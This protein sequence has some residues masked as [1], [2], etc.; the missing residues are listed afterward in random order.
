MKFK[1]Q[2]VNKAIRSIEEEFQSKHGGRYLPEKESKIFQ[3]HLEAKARTNRIKN[4]STLLSLST[5]YLLTRVPRSFM[6]N[7][8]LLRVCSYLGVGYAHTVIQKR[9]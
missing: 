2:S 3:W 4:S 5:F 1:Q 8:R 7:S 6:M 9:L